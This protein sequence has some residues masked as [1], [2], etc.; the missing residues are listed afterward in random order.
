[1]HGPTSALFG[2]RP[3]LATTEVRRAPP[4]LWYE[5]IHTHSPLNFT[6]KI[7]FSALYNFL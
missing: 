1:M 7:I 3:H 5:A 2:S 4:Q 6:S